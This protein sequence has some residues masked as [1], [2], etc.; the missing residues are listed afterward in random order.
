M[1]NDFKENYPYKV[2]VSSESFDSLDD[3][4]FWCCK[5]LATDNSWTFGLSNDG[6]NI[7]DYFFKNKEDAVNFQLTWG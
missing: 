5:N 6:H 3:P 7:V 2:S 1:T 4:W